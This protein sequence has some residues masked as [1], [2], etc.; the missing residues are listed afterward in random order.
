M[1]SD[2]IKYIM[3]YKI[4]PLLSLIN[5]MDI[6]ATFKNWEYFMHCICKTYKICILLRKTPQRT[7]F[8]VTFY[9]VKKVYR[10]I[11]IHI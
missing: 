8:C 11:I 3:F 5:V 4:A 2:I 1:P 9:F 10:K 6:K 7:T